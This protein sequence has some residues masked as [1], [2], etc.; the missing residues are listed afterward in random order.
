MAIKY[1]FF[2]NTE[3]GFVKEEEVIV[4]CC[5]GLQVQRCLIRYKVNGNREENPL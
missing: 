2:L 5:V 3:N 1:T 4:I